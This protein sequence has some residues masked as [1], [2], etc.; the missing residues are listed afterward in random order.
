M[1][2]KNMCKAGRMMDGN[3]RATSQQLEED[4]VVLV[5]KTV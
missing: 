3:K 1:D 4:A 2:H 5:A